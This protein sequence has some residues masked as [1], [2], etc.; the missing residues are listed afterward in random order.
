MAMPP[1]ASE[2][3]E[4]VIPLLPEEFQTVEA[5]LDALARACP[6]TSRLPNDILFTPVPDVRVGHVDL[7]RARLVDCLFSDDRW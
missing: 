2:P 5:R 1:S 7:G 6:H 4:F 3:L